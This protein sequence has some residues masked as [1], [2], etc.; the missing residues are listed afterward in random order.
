MVVPEEFKPLSA[1]GIVLGSH[2]GNQVAPP[3]VVF[4]ITETLA[5][6]LP[7]PPQAY[8]TIGLTAYTSLITSVV[9]LVCADQVWP[10]SVVFTIV[11]GEPTAQ[12]VCSSAMETE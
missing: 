10:P 6:P 8:A 2:N 9:P 1:G 7:P 12:P 4:S 3:S 5:T 11:P